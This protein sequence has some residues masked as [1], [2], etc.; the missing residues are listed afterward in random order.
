MFEILKIHLNNP[1]IKKNHG[2]NINKIF[3]N[4]L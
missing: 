2:G 3:L 1:M 4:K